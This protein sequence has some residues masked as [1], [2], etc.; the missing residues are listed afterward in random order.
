MEIGNEQ[1]AGTLHKEAAQNEKTLFE[2]YM[3]AAHQLL[4][5]IDRFREG[6][7]M[8]GRLVKIAED[9]E[10]G[11]IKVLLVFDKPTAFI[12]DKREQFNALL[13]WLHIGE[14]YL[15]QG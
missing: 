13:E 6:A 2:K 8:K 5:D 12:P 1:G 9:R 15:I 7:V 14:A 4:S 10:D 3:E 11:S